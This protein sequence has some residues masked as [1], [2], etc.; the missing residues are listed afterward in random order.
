[1]SSASRIALQRLVFRY[2]WPRYWGNMTYYTDYPY[3]SAEVCDYICEAGV[4]LIAM[5]TPSPDDPINGPSSDN[6]S[7]N[8]KTLL[9]N[10]VV[11]V[12]YLCNLDQIT[13]PIVQLV[14][15]PL[16]IQQGD[17]APARCIAIEEG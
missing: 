5:D 11:I 13:A 8:H 16:K 15:L 1:M 17:G 6:D 2:D 10:D 14:V 3:L 4:R 9:G 12:E 7:P